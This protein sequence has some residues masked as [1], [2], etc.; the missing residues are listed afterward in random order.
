MRCPLTKSLADQIG[1]WQAAVDHAPTTRYSANLICRRITQDL[2]H[3]PLIELTARDLDLWY[4]QLAAEGMTPNTIR[5]YHAIIRAVLAYA[6]DWQDVDRNVALSAHPPKAVKIDETD[7][8]PTREDVATIL[9]GIRSDTLRVAILLAATTGMRRGEIVALQWADLR[10]GTLWVSRS[11]YKVPGQ[12]LGYKTPKNR[13]PKVIPLNPSMLSQLDRYARW[14]D[15]NGLGDTPMMFTKPD[16]TGFPP[17][18][19]SQEWQRAC[20]RNGMRFK[21]H[22]LRHLHGS[23]LVD[24]GV[25][26]TT[27]AARQGHSVQTMTAHYLHPVNA[28]AQAA[29]DVI[30][31]AF[32]DLF[33]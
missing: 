6:V 27:A 18:W 24:S 32:A 2:G 19:L 3:H 8:V 16:G 22:G 28:S 11:A 30:E 14:Q 33:N 13:K 1:D 17:D 23:T 26:L 29:A 5:H 20:A 15:T 31:H 10:D 25:S 12:P 4:R 7:R 9:S 21:F